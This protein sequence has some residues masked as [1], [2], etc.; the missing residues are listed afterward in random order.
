VVADIGAAEGIFALSIVEKAKTI[1]L[2]EC[3]LSWFDALKKT[4]EPWAEKCV[5]VNKYIG[6]HTNNIYISI[7]DFFSDKHIDFIKSDIEGAEIDLLQ[8]AHLTMTGQRKLKM[9]L[10]SY[11]KKDEAEN[12]ENILRANGFYVEFTKGFML[13]WLDDQFADP[14]IRRGVIMGIKRG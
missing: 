14:Y 13:F 3:D 7:D 4:F 9:L 1:Y 11:H 5:F 12:I 6:A 8:G 10:C 2:F